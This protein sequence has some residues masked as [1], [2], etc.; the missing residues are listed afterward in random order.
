MGRSGYWT[1][2]S[3]TTSPSPVSLVRKSATERG[4]EAIRLPHIGVSV[5]TT[6]TGVTTVAAPVVEVTHPYA[7]SSNEP[8]YSRS[9]TSRTDDQGYINV[10]FTH[11]WHP[12]LRM[13]FSYIHYTSLS[14]I[15]G[16]GSTVEHKFAFCGEGVR[17]GV[18]K[19]LTKFC[20]L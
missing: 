7:L 19:H 14:E 9:K 16:A 17:G 2:T 10:M 3:N 12:L 8:D 18:F 4:R 11:L 6:V 1:T 5:Q 15:C 20:F 13:P